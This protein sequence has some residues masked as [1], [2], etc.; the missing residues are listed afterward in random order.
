MR[1][2]RFDDS[3]TQPNDD[4][5]DLLDEA[6]GKEVKEEPSIA[7]QVMRSIERDNTVWIPKPE[8]P[9][10]PERAYLLLET[11]RDGFQIMSLELEDEDDPT[12]H[13]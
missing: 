11:L 10:I 5:D 2:I 4:L 6:L 9:L 13:L 3:A 7:D 1:G 12:N 8:L